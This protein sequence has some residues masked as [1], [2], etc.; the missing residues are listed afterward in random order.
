MFPTSS[1]SDLVGLQ[2]RGEKFE[3]WVEEQQAGRKMLRAQHRRIRLCWCGPIMQHA[4]ILRAFLFMWGM[5]E[6]STAHRNWQGRST[7]SLHVA[8][9]VQA[10]GDRKHAIGKLWLKS[11]PAVWE[12]HGDLDV[13]DLWDVN[14]RD[15][16]ALAELCKK[17]DA[18]VR[19]QRGAL[20]VSA[21]SSFRKAAGF[22][23][24]GQGGQ[25]GAVR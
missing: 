11:V 19:Q 5:M 3:E 13:S 21:G 20:I 14:T 9:C 2:H 18:L 22:H 15:Q 17:E 6:W 25:G 7:Q 8:L 12:V 16:R 24:A 1:S 10:Q 23:Q 4:N